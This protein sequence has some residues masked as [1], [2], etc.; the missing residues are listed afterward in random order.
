M[1]YIPYSLG[2]WIISAGTHTGAMKYVGEAV[3]DYQLA[4]RYE[5]V[6][7]IGISTWGA[8]KHQH[9]LIGEQVTKIAVLVGT[10]MLSEGS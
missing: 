8:L 3:R 1:L 5:E 6:V 4:Y 9:K 7:A 10:S 2:A